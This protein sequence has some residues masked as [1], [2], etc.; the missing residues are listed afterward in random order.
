MCVCVCIFVFFAAGHNYSNI[1]RIVIPLYLRGSHV[2]L[3]KEAVFVEGF[4][5]FIY[6]L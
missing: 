3:G 4:P 6:S 2:Q 5:D 1:A